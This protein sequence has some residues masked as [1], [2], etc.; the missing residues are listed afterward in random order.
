M[1]RTCERHARKAVELPPYDVA[2]RMAG[3]SVSRQQDDV[4][5]QDE[6][7]DSH[8]NSSIKNESVQRVAPKKEEKDKPHI[9]KVAMEIL[10]NKRKPS[11]APV[12]MLPALTDSTGGR[13]EEESPVVSLPIVVAR[14]PKSQRPNQNQERRREW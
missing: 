7:A 9:Q 11:L 3:Q 6:S 12:T 10:Q 13:I 5:Q 14:D 8:S 2:E 1:T 4:E